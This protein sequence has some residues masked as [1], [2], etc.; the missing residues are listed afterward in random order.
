MIYLLLPGF[1]KRNKEEII[2]I[3]ETLRKDGKETFIHFWKHWSDEG[4]KWDPEI[5]VDNI[6][7]EIKDT[8]LSS[9]V[10]IGKS[11]GTFISILLIQKLGILVK[12]VILMGIP[13]NSLGRDEQELYSVVLKKYQILT[14]IIQNIQ[15]P[16]GSI[17]QVKNLLG[18]IRY[19]LIE[20]DASDHR[21]NY[22]DKILSIV[23]NTNKN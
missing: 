2:N 22:P 7:E 21:Y 11:I 4:I 12:Q 13:V 20:I 5:E 16:H 9:V 15:D 19:D 10:I 14:T 18:S 8:N 6:Y 17:S 3:S 1:S 23:N